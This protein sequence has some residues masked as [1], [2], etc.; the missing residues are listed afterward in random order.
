MV[1]EEVVDSRAGHEAP[2]RGV[3]TS[4][5]VEGDVA[6]RSSGD[7]IRVVQAVEASPPQDPATCQPSTS[8]RFT[9]N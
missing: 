7:P 4:V 6:D 9:S 2:D 3:R 5:I 8:T 1:F